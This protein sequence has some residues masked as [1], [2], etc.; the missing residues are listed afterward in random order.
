MGGDLTYLVSIFIFAGFPLLLE[1]VFGY[2]FFKPHWKTIGKF[3]LLSLILTPFYERVALHFKA[4]QYN[5]KRNLGITIFTIP[6]ETYVFTIFVALA[7][8]LA[9]YIWTFYEDNNQPI[10]RT[11][12]RDMFI[13]KYAIWRKKEIMSS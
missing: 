11:S 13:G 3:L 2:H 9:V 10:L 4:W 1:F 5:P 12:L 8:A 6:L 7:I